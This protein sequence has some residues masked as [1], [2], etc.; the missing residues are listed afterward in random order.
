MEIIDIL[1]LVAIVILS[2]FCIYLFRISNKR[3][4]NTIALAPAPNLQQP[5]QPMPVPVPNLQQPV[6][7]PVPAP[8]LI[9]FIKDGN[10]YVMKY[11]GDNQLFANIVNNPNYS[12]S[13]KLMYLYSNS[14]VDIDTMIREG[15][16]L[17]ARE[18]G[19]YKFQLHGYNYQ[20]VSTSGSGNSCLLHAIFQA[21]SAVYRYLQRR[22]S[23][24]TPINNIRKSV[25]HQFIRDY[26]IDIADTEIRK[27]DI[28]GDIMTNNQLLIDTYIFIC[29]MID[30]NVFNPRLSIN[31]LSKKYGSKLSNYLLDNQ[32][33]IYDKIASN[34]R[35]NNIDNP[36]IEIAKIVN[37]RDNNLPYNFSNLLSG[38][39]YIKKE[40]GTE[41][42]E[43]IIC[44]LLY[45]WIAEKYGNIPQFTT[46][47]EYN[48]ILRENPE[49]K[50]YM[51]DRIYEFSVNK[52]RENNPNI[53]INSD[54]VIK[55][56]N[57]YFTSDKIYKIYNM[58]DEFLKYRNILNSYLFNTPFIDA[59]FYD[60][61]DLCNDL[62]IANKTPEILSKLR[63]IYKNIDIRIVDNPQ[64]MDGIKNKIM[65]N[66]LKN[67]LDARNIINGLPTDSED[68]NK[69]IALYNTIILYKY[70]TYNYTAGEFIHVSDNKNAIAIYIAPDSIFSGHYNTI[71]G[72]IDMSRI[73]GTFNMVSDNQKF[74]NIY[75]NEMLVDM[76]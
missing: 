58:D 70:Y 54:I 9:N 30:R 14:D 28:L 42:D 19:E 4:V 31:Q 12:V 2:G 37:N 33:Y 10:R 74:V 76:I 5:A 56:A 40:L 20:T 39:I 34:D 60:Y 43:G 48:T 61:D 36:L 57:T 69:L 21:D 15:A 44:N 75:N 3:S 71:R 25:L 45:K 6:P 53:S 52:F 41:D 55:I 17:F 47:R 8:A 13:D 16:D 67:M 26:Y 51:E 64:N 32:L 62:R 22:N 50:K 65:I 23:I 73:I 68:K 11:N 59:P 38:K 29:F 63:E 27:A 35:N 66:D 49:I 24:A 1:L 7:V 46:Y 72:T 18:T